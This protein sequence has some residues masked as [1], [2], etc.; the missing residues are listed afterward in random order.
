[1]VRAG[2]VGLCLAVLISGCAKQ[3]REAMYP[4]D[5]LALAEKLRSE[6][7]C[8]KAVPHY[9]KLLSEFPAKHIAEQ[10]KFNLARCHKDLKE[11]DQ[12]IAGFEDFIDTYPTSQLVDDAMYL[13]AMCYLEQ[14]P[15]PERDQSMTMKAL[16]ELKL[17]LREY[18]E[19]DLR[20][21]I[22]QAI[23][24]CRS[25]LAEKE[26]LNGRLY[27]RLGYPK[28]AIIYFDTVINDYGDTRWAGEALLGKGIAL[29]D[30]GRVDEAR[31]VFEQVIERYPSSDLAKDAAKHL[32][33]LGGGKRSDKWTSQDSRS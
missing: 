21:E 18:P 19:T 7:K 31:Q 15:I 9:E 17:I 13:I 32:N 6:G 24:I 26:Y 8:Y 28:S 25:K 10:A 4:E 14:A 11:Y 29:L 1:M 3:T 20:S 22:E 12:A 33:Q 27:L 30:Q 16:E 5:R 2:V 23:E